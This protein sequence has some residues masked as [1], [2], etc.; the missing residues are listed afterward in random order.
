MPVALTHLASLALSLPHALDGEAETTGNV[1][2]GVISI[3]S[4]VLAYIGLFALWY[5]VF[6]DRAR[7]KR[8]K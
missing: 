2:L 6:R 1:G 8:K 4:V 7:S 5:F 3:V